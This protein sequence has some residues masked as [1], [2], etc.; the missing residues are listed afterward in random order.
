M[1]QS[2]VNVNINLTGEK[3]QKFVEDYYT[4]PKKMVEKYINTFNASNNL[5][6]LDNIERVE[7]NGK[8]NNKNDKSDVFFYYRR[9]EQ[10]YGISV[11]QSKDATMSN[12]SVNLILNKI[13]NNKNSSI[14][15]D[16]IKK[17]YIR[18]QGLIINDKLHRAKINELFYDHFNN[19][20]WNKMRELIGKNSNEMG[21]H[22]LNATHCINT[23]TIVY[24]YDGSSMYEFI[25]NCVSSG[26]IVEDINY[27]TLKDD[28]P[29]K[30]AK[31]FYNIFLDGKKIYRCEIRHK[32]SWSASPQFMLFK[33]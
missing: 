8:C 14:E 22:I 10:K 16:N 17:S 24:E 29:R 3:Y 7:L 18:E 4:R 31:M 1:R 6:N 32:G 26:D 5:I 11:K 12:Y 2:G 20:Y 15:L 23:E 25:P 19:P 33:V 27:Y 28:T 21:K 9:N 30:T 13:A